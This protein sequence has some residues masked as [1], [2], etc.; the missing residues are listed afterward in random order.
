VD[1]SICG[2]S[3]DQNTEIR[4]IVFGGIYFVLEASA[5]CCVL[6]ERVSLVARQL[7]LVWLRLPHLRKRKVTVG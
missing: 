6:C 3:E 1:L 4:V 2:S 7:V 5:Y